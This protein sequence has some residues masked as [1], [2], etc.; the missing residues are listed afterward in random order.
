[1]TIL[2]V[3]RLLILTFLLAAACGGGAGGPLGDSGG[4]GAQASGI[5]LPREISA[6]PTKGAPTSVAAPV[7][8]GLVG[9]VQSA[10]VAGSDYDAARTVKFV[11]EQALSQFD[12]FNTIFKALEQTHYADPANVNK[13]PY[14]AVVT[15]IEDRGDR[16][17]KELQRWVVDS[18]V[19]QVDG[20]D[21]NRVLLW[22]PTEMKDGKRHFIEARLDI[23]S[24]P[25]QKADGSYS[26]YGVWRIDARA[27]V[28]AEWS[29][30]ATSERGTAGLAVVK[31][32]QTEG[33][34]Q[35]TRGIL[36]K[37][38]THGMGKVVFP[39]WSSCNS[40]SCQPPPATV[41]YV[42]DADHVALAKAGA[43][44]VF[45]SRTSFV[46]LV[47]RYGLYDS[48]TGADVS[49]SHSFGFPVRYIDAQGVEQYGYY[50]AWQG[51]HQ[52]WGNGK[53]IPPGTTVLRG[54][55]APGQAPESYTVSDA[56]QGILV[57]RTLVPASIGDVKDI[58]VNTWVNQ[59]MNLGWDGAQ[60]SVCLNPS[61]NPIGPPTCD[62][63]SGPITD[64]SF[65]VND[66]NN[67][68]HNVNIGHWNQTAQRSEALVYDPSGL[69]GPGF[70]VASESPGAPPTS[71]GVKYVPSLNDQLWAGI[72]DSIY[73]Y[74]NGTG[75]QRKKVVAFDSNTF[76]P[77]FDPA[78]DQP[79]T[80]ELNREYYINN[81]GGGYVVKRTGASTYDVKI[82]RQTVGNPVNAAA[83]APAGTLFKRPWGGD[84]ST[85][86]RFVTDSASPAFLKLVYEVVGAQDAQAGKKAGDVLASGE[87]GLVAL[88]NGVATSDQY[89]WEYP[90]AN[91]DPNSSFGA[92]QFL[93]AGGGS[94]RI[95][96]NPI[97][98]Q[99][100]SL[101]GGGGNAKTYALQFDGS[102]VGGLPNFFDDLRKAGMVMTDAIA[103]EVV[104]IPSGT[105]VTDAEDATKQY[106][107]KQLQV[108]EF[109]RNIADPGNLDVTAAGALDL[110]TAPSFV[111]HGMGAL[112]DVPLKYSEGNP[113]Q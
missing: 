47:N 52:L 109:L 98:L 99:P 34:G 50:G 31:L 13:G 77:T 3:N 43:A 91:N 17:S 53:T 16:Q 5:A 78:G 62:P 4:G 90:S 10:L 66:P 101:V 87:W 57:K 18:S 14:G 36:Q 39:D 104:S 23:S 61:F 37:S 1:M 38:E 111:E 95:L 113:V 106:V 69:S 79:Y 97:R 27:D 11:N 58:V 63:G 21:V 49:R 44:V 67:R 24:A 45:K 12:V 33:L 107:F 72:N 76:T 40:P 55:L 89:N 25:T 28:S 112:P 42:Y 82:E 96:D 7:P 94:Y 41:A 29:F 30:T 19:I 105:L 15:W 9:R 8:G 93:E 108:S 22:I 73:V 75:W 88:V 85:T 74:F 80:L 60:W 70:Y 46:D 100:I 35:E 59:G 20:K 48:A 6:L 84:A 56:F 102:W 32:H 65:L 68:V 71:T 51:R 26:D 64:F 110:A 92:Q 2:R 103:A 86:F 83:F 54:D 81:N